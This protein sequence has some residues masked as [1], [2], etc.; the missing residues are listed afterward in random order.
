MKLK[1]CLLFLSIV[2]GVFISACN[3]GTD[4]RVAL[5]KS[6]ISP[7]SQSQQNST[8]TQ[9]ADQNTLKDSQDFQICI[10]NEGLGGT[11]QSYNN[12]PIRDNFEAN[13]ESN[14][15][16]PISITKSTSIVNV[17]TPTGGFDCSPLVVSGNCTASSNT[18]LANLITPVI[19]VKTGR[20]N[21]SV[22]FT[23]Q[24]VNIDLGFL[25][26]PQTLGCDSVVFSRTVT[27]YSGD[28]GGVNSCEITLNIQPA[29]GDYGTINI[30]TSFMVGSVFNNLD[31]N[32]NGFIPPNIVISPEQSSINLQQGVSSASNS[33]TFDFSNQSSYPLHIDNLAS[34][35][36]FIKDSDGCGTLLAAN[37]TCKVAGHVLPITAIGTTQIIYSMT[38]H[39]DYGHSQTYQSQPL[40]VNVTKAPPPNVTTTLNNPNRIVTPFQNQSPS[41]GLQFTFTNT[42]AGNITITGLNSGDYIYPD[43]SK[44]IA[45]NL[46]LDNNSCAG[47]TLAQNQSC[48]ISSHFFGNVIGSGY[49]NYVLSYNDQY[50]N[51]WATN[52]INA[53]WTVDPNTN[54]PIIFQS[55]YFVVT[56]IES[57]GWAGSNS[58][59]GIA[60]GSVG[61]KGYTLYNISGTDID[62]SKLSYLVVPNLVQSELAL[63]KTQTNNPC[64][65]SLSNGGQSGTLTGVI[66]STTKQCDIIFKYSPTSASENGSVTWSSNFPDM[67]KQHMMLILHNAGVK[68]HN[69]YTDT[70]N[71]I[72]NMLYSAKPSLHIH[73]IGGAYGGQYWSSD[74]QN[75]TMSQVPGVEYHQC[76]NGQTEHVL[77]VGAYGGVIYT[78]DESGLTWTSANTNQAESLNSVAVDLNNRIYVAV[79]NN[80]T[81]LAMNDVTPNTWIKFASGT[82]GK[83]TSVAFGLGHFVIVSPDSSS[84]WVSQGSGTSMTW[85]VVTTANPFTSITFDGN[86]F[87]AVGVGG[88]VATSSTGSSWSVGSAWMESAETTPV[89]KNLVSVAYNNGVY[90]AISADGV[91]L[92]STDGKTWFYRSTLSYTLNTISP[93]FTSGETGFIVSGKNYVAFTTDMQHFTALYNPNGY[94]MFSAVVTTDEDVVIYVGNSGRIIRDILQ[95]GMFSTTPRVLFPPQI[96]QSVNA[97]AYDGNATIVGVGN[98]G[99]VETSTDGKLW[100]FESSGTTAFM[101][102]VLFVNNTFVAVGNG[103]AITSNSGYNWTVH[104]LPVNHSYVDEDSDNNVIVGVGKLGNPYTSTQ[105][106]IGYS[107]DNG[108]T[109]N[110]LSNQLS[111][112]TDL[113]AI[114]HGSSGFV[115]IDSA[116]KI[117]TSADGKTWSGPIATGMPLVNGMVYGNG[118]YVAAATGAIYTSSDM[119]TWTKCGGDDLSRYTFYGVDQV[120]TNS[121]FIA[122]GTFG[123]IVDIKT[124]GASAT[125]IVQQTNSSIQLF[126][127]QYIN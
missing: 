103:Q 90:A 72:S 98:G 6:G 19:T 21:G 43:Y 26:P 67:I 85:N 45:A 97:Y 2:F 8:G 53:R 99:M 116:S 54:K 124:N 60:V 11:C 68:L 84:V 51:I 105:A 122:V 91:S 58:L 77:C 38:G 18:A 112:A 115:T 95:N 108:V 39:D 88:H 107:A 7:I 111:G 3:G 62:T 40:T 70:V 86:K 35:A 78:T 31:V 20:F 66:S 80:G 71:M 42:S 121:E 46:N 29:S 126:N 37:S 74:D 104:N 25:Y 101:K 32:I 96:N 123:T 76:V 41:A 110:D 50:G 47:A 113:R 44:T 81:I 27:Y 17:V 24:T 14:I 1:M 75:W 13:D 127:Y 106:A 34:P 65:V 52:S 63:D 119:K 120:G 57:Q 49:S 69:A 48:T 4:N 102:Q 23:Y 82:S 33:T 28:L 109:W 118:T 100:N 117:Y 83:L 114:A 30:G 36:G 55:P 64:Q 61:Y 92:A 94:N 12:L 9:L 16:S 22:Y 79:G 10:A 125:C 93:V 5:I 59:A 15:S 89:T 87:I 56:D 73:L